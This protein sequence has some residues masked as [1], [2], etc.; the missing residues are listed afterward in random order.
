[1]AWKIDLRKAYDTIDWNFL[2]SMLEN[3]KFPRKFIAW[4]MMCVQSTSYSIMINGEMVDFFEGKRGLRQGDPISPFLF[5]IAME[6]LSRLMQ[7]LNKAEGFYYHPKCHRI[8]LTHIMFADDLI[9]FSSGRNS[10]IGAI[11]EAVH[12]FLECS[13]LSINVHKSNLFMGGMGAAKV[14]WVEDM[15]GTKSSPLP[16]RYL[17]LPL[18]SRS[19]SRKDCD[20]LIQKITTRLDCWSSRYL[21]RAGRRVLVFSVLQSMVFFWARV[22]LLPKTVIQEVNSICARFLWCGNCDKKGGHLV[23][24][25]DVCRDKVEGGLGLKNLECM[26]YAMVICQMWGNKGS[27]AG[28]WSDWLDK[29]WNKGK[30]WWEVGVKPSSSWVIKRLMQCK[31]IG[32]QCVSIDNNSIRWT[33]NGDGFE[34]KDTYSSIIE[35]KEEVGWHKMVWNDYN[36]PRDSLNAWLVVQ[37]KLL[38][39]IG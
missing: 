24:W 8:K 31:E 12:K 35:H 7:N 33:G 36:A 17:G 27:R 1:M 2:K 19:L 25:V 39:R 6:Y 34:V 32:L 11:K 5:T 10:S 38:T 28:L 20:S 9:I 30:H 26:N 15:I 21:S 29:Y 13:G 14:A 3:L 4:M 18:T 16:V 23:K 37:N 22:C